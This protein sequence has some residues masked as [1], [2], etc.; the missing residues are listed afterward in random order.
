MFECIFWIQIN[1]IYI[2][3]Y[4]GYLTNLV[5]MLTHPWILNKFE[6]YLKDNGIFQIGI[7][8]H[9]NRQTKFQN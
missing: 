4:L 5:D 7:E 8:D 9:L 1:A 3:T 2:R 6:N